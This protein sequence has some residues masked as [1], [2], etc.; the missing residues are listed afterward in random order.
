MADGMRCMHP[1]DVA[2]TDPPERL[3]SPPEYGPENTPEETDG[4]AKLFWR[5]QRSAR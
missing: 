3:D 5:L 4:S 2:W 1:P